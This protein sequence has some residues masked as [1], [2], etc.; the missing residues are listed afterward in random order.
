[1]S[2]KYTIIGLCGLYKA[3]DD[4]ALFNMVQMVSLRHL[5][6][7]ISLG[8][9]LV[10]E[11]RA[12]RKWDYEPI[13]VVGISSNDSLVSF[14]IQIIRIGR[15]EYGVSGTAV[16]NYDTTDETTME[17]VAYR[18]S[19]GAES[20]YKLL[21]FSVPKQSFNDYIN[22]YYKEV[23]MKNLAHCSNL[24]QFKGK[25]QPP[26]PKKTYWAEKCV[27]KCDGL[28]DI[29]LPGLY[30]VVFNCTGPNQPSWDFIGI[31]KLRNKMF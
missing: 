6:V 2:C 26:W 29:I 27:F 28:P 25:F 4:R 12:A 11:I 21:P 15:G 5:F 13:S 1:M 20:D 24:P 19:T 31:V 9:L 17:A 18:S 23:I 30:K 10:N 8:V 16:W 22:S 7:S 14:D 3:M